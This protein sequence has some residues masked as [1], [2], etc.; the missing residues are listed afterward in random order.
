MKTDR[1]GHRNSAK[2]PAALSQKCLLGRGE[3]KTLKSPEGTS[4][5]TN[6][7]HL[8]PWS[9]AGL[10]ATIS[11]LPSTLSAQTIVNGDFETGAE[12]FVTGPGYVG[13]GSNPPVIPGWIGGTGINPIASGDAPFIDN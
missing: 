4:F 11:L 2:L 3:R 10:L 5:F 7:R 9:L 8:V 1:R 12:Q 6:L 13:D